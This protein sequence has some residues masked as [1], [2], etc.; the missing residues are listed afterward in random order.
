M[1]VALN[2]AGQECRAFQVDNRR[3][4]GFDGGSWPN[5]LNF[6]APNQH[7]PAFVHGVTIENTVG[8]EQLGGLCLK[9]I[10]KRK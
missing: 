1:R 7:H 8:A 6:G 3:V 4:V 10:C 9:R 2:H 5:S